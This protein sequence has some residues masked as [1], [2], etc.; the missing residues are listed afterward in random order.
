MAANV[1]LFP[2]ADYWWFYAAFTGGVLLLLA[3]DLGV[4][5]RD[6]REISFREAAA[7]EFL[8]GY[9]VEYSLAVDN[10]FVFVLVLS[11]F[12]VPAKYQHRVLF[13]GILGALV[14]RALFIA[15]GSLL[16]QFHW[17]VWIFGAF[18]VFTLL[19]LVSQPDD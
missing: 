16:L 19:Q 14:F 18:L 11:Y 2:F 9:V 1:P 13:Y 5:R 6:A 12:A 8:A 15:L 3:L 7:L 10:I 17:V 4:L